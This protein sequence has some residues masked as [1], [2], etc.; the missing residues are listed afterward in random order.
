MESMEKPFK[1]STD[2]LNIEVSLLHLCRGACLS[3]FVTMGL[4]MTEETFQ[5]CLRMY[6]IDRYYWPRLFCN[7]IPQS[8]M[9]YRFT[10]NCL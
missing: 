7:S 2:A 8:S 4:C 3:V 9:K 5:I 1:P 6:D 10:V